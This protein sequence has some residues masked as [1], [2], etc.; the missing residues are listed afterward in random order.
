M[1]RELIVMFLLQCCMFL[2]TLILFVNALQ[3]HTKQRAWF[4]AGVLVLMTVSLIIGAVK[5]FSY[6]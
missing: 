5:L 4:I 6:L 1:P 3:K 2:S